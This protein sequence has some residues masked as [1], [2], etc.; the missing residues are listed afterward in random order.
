M[1]AIR[2]GILI[3]SLILSGALFLCTSGCVSAADAD[4]FQ[5]YNYGLTFRSHRYT[6]DERTSLNLT[7]HKHLNLKKGFRIDFELRLNHEDAAYGYVMR[8]IS[9]NDSAL[10]INANINTGNLNFVL[11]N[12]DNHILNVPY[13]DAINLESGR[14]MHI[15]LTIDKSEIIC[16]VD[17]VTR[18]IGNELSDLS[19]IE[20]WFGTCGDEK[21][22]STDVAPMTIR[23]IR[24]STGK[25]PLR[26][27]ELCRNNGTEVY[28]EIHNAVASVSNGIWEIDLHTGWTKIWSEEFRSQPELAYDTGTGHLFVASSDVVVERDLATGNEIRTEIKGGGPFVC[29]GSQM[30]YDPREK[31][32]ISYSFQFRDFSIFDFTTG[33][34]SSSNREDIPR[35]QQHS[36]FFDSSRRLLYA[37][38]GYGNHLYNADFYSRDID[39]N[40][41][42]YRD[43]S[44][45]IAPRYLAAMGKL[46]DGQFLLLG[47]FGNLSGR[48]EESPRNMYDVSIIN[49]DEGTAKRVS[50]FSLPDDRYSMSSTLVCDKKMGKIYSLAFDNGR[51]ASSL[52]LFSISA[53]DTTAVFYGNPIPYT[54][55]DIESYSELSFSPDST[56]LYTIV[57]NAVNSSERGNRVEVYALAYPPVAVE[58]ARQSVRGKNRLAIVLTLSGLTLLIAIVSAFVFIALQKKRRGRKTEILPETTTPHKSDT[59]RQPSSISLLGGLSIIDAEGRNVTTEFTP[60]VRQLLLLILMNSRVKPVGITSEVLD[61]KLW[62]GMEKKQAANNRNVNM[63]KLRLKLEKVWNVELNNKNGYWFFDIDELSCCDYLE[64][65]QLLKEVMANPRDKERLHR[66][67][68]LVMSGSLLPD[69]DF[70]W[71]DDYKSS[72]TNMIVESLV[73]IQRLYDDDYDMSIMIARAMRVQDIIDEE[74]VR[75]Y[76]R[77][78]YRNGNK[79]LSRSVW[80]KFTEDYRK[81]MG[82]LPDFSYSQ[83]I[84]A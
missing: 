19:D 34:W 67:L 18:V 57:S 33:R 4:G 82:T 32:L 38:G 64:V 40:S 26:N 68:T 1:K 58:L 39:S 55:H 8:L 63:R 45:E 79:S 9:G 17:G 59:E 35:N 66:L 72:Y 25:G 23:D 31:R 76:C 36:R 73:K 10:D 51:S 43:F 20:I 29:G 84:N 71:L 28:D 80:D 53:Q 24:I 44:T 70:E 49:P 47:G 48:Q 13:H 46:D 65:R 54:F 27:W 3:V 30:I 16:S 50:G 22:Y 11:I 21:F 42:H 5:S 12:G 75:I 69:N 37:F 83:I 62:Y 41:W 74:A 2:T 56:S 78:L 14:W 77:A 7:P 6:I 81:V 60:I 61:D 15:N 52:N